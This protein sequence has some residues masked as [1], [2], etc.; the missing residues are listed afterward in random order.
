M[1][2]IKIKHMLRVI[3]LSVVLGMF[4]VSF[5]S[6]QEEFIKAK[7]V[8]KVPGMD[9]VKI[10]SDITYKETGG[11]ELKMD[12]FQPPNL[13]P[14]DKLPAV[15]YIHGGTL[16]PDYPVMPKSWEVYITH[17]RLIA[18]SGMVG[19]TFNHR[20][21]GVDKQNLDNS[22][23]DVR[24]AIKYV[25]ENAKK[26][27]I[28][29]DRICL[30]GFSGGGSHLSVALQ[31]K[32]EYVRCIVSYYGVMN[33][34]SLIS[35]GRNNL[36]W[37]NGYAPVDYLTLENYQI[38]PF[39]V[40]RAGLDNPALN[41]T[42]DAF[43]TKALD[44]NIDIEIANHPGGVHGFDVFNDDRRTR[45]ILEDTISF[46]KR[47]IYAE[48]T[49]DESMLML[50]GRLLKI[51]QNGDIQKVKDIITGKSGNFTDEQRTS[52]KTVVTEQALNGMGYSFL[53]AG[54]PTKA[55]EL[56]EWITQLYPNSP[57]ALDSLADGYEAAGNI[58]LAI[59][60]SDKAI[61]L[62]EKAVNLNENTKNNLKKSAVERLKRLQK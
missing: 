32:M 62:L 47:N 45:E 54:N 52:L 5:A 56:F 17:G 49:G 35:G 51:I 20:Y 6:S 12:I 29:P 23:S 15:L 60:S 3:C 1:V 39:F 57:N 41:A 22:F 46:I 42:I 37:M 24:D 40:A 18:A 11:K 10:F 25:R 31:D 27:N 38:P 43:I 28:D 7:V 30:W 58:D 34:K 8:Y 19:V 59:K 16:P 33:L 13:K 44:M 61:Q 4:F 21:Y 53:A 26:Y 36:D 48:R 55:V 2:S 50:K 14:N 9:K